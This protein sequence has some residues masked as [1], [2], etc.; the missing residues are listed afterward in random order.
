MQKIR[1]REV[2][3]SEKHISEWVHQ[4]GK[5]A[6]WGPNWR[7][8]NQKDHFLNPK[9]KNGRHHG[10]GNFDSKKLMRPD[11]MKW[12]LKMIILINATSTNFFNMLIF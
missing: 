12:A 2:M 6:I 7:N 3:D 4:L 9:P 10:R 1:S 8:I 11:L 5:W